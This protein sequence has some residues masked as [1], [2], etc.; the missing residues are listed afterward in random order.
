MQAWSNS[1][2]ARSP[3]FGPLDP[4]PSFLPTLEMLE[5]RAL[6]SVTVLDDLATTTQEVSVTIPVLNN[7]SDPQDAGPLMIDSVGNPSNGTTMLNGASIDYLPDASFVGIDLFTYVARD[8]DGNLGSGTVTVGVSTPSNTLPVAMDDTATIMEDTP[9]QLDVLSNDTDDDDDNLTIFSVSMPENGTTT[10]S[11]DKLSILYTPTPNTNG[12]DS[13]VYVIS[14]GNGGIAQATVSVTV[15]PVNDAPIANP[16]L[17]NLEENDP[18][19]TLNLIA[20]DTEPEG[21]SLEVFAVTALNPVD[22][23]TR[24]LIPEGVVFTPATDYVGVVTFVYNVSDP[25]GGS[26]GIDTATVTIGVRD[27]TNDSIPVANDDLFTVDEDSRNNPLPILDNDTDADTQDRLIVF[28]VMQPANGT[29]TIASNTLSV[30]YTPDADFFG[31]DTFTYITTDTRGAVAS[32]TVTITVTNASDD[33]VANDD[34]FN[35]IQNATA[36]TLDVLANDTDPDDNTLSI[37]EVT[38]P[39]NGSVSIAADNQSLVF[40][41]PMDFTGL[42]SFTYTISDGTGGVSTARVVVGIRDD[43]VNANPPTANDDTFDTLLEDSEDNVLDVLANDTDPDEDPLSI[44][45]VGQAN[46]GGT[47]VIDD[48]RLLYTPSANFVGTETFTYTISDGAGGVDLAT[49]TVVVENVPENFPPIAADDLDTTSVGVATTIDVLANDQDPDNAPAPLA[50]LSVANPSVGTASIDN[51]QVL[52]TPPTDFVGTATFT[53]TITDGQDT[54]SATVSVTVTSPTNQ[55]PVANPDTFAAT[56]NSGPITLDVLAN[57]SDPD[58]DSLT[59]TATSVP[60]NGGTVSIAND[61]SSLMYQPATDFLG[62]ETFTYTI[63]DGQGGLAT[64]TV[65]IVVNLGGPVANDDQF[66]VVTTTPTT[67][68]VLSNDS[69]VAGGTLTISAVSQ[70][71]SG[72]VAI[73][74]DN[75]ALTFTAPAGFTGELTFTYTVADGTGDSDTAEVTITV[76]T[77]QGIPQAND[78]SFRVFA[79]STLSVDASQSLLMNDTTPG[80]VPL[81]VVDPES[82][83]LL[84]GDGT[85][86]VNADGTF[87]FTPT[88]GFQGTVR[89]DYTASNGTFSDT[90]SV[91]ILVQGRSVA[92]FTQFA[93]SGGSGSQD[94]FVYDATTGDEAPAYQVT[95]F[96][97]A[98]APGG[99]RVALADV[100]GDGVP[101]V[102]A[103][104]GPGVSASVRILDGATQEPLSTITPFPLDP[105]FTGGVYVAAGD[106]NGDGFA[107]I[108]ITP[109]QGG[110]PVVA[111]YNGS[112]FVELKRFFGIEGDPNFRGG[113]RPALGDLNG[114][115]FLDVLISAGFQGGPRVA[116]FD[117]SNLLSTASNM[118]PSKIVGD[119]FVFEQSLRDG[120][121]LAAGDIDGDGMAELITG[122]GPQGGPRIRAFSGAVLITGDFNTN[123]PVEAQIANFFASNPNNRGGI[124]VTVRQTD[125]PQLR[126]AIVSAEGPGILPIVN[127]FSAENLAADP[128]DPRASDS[129]L[130]FPTSFLGGVFVG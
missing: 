71:S 92:S 82:I 120:A 22:A 14:D 32:A 44:V 63:S 1:M 125:D 43:Q 56:Q 126:A 68:D 70:P 64:T 36:T 69:V 15:T 130:P 85:L 102:I 90:A 40:T 129:L 78:D 109:D 30:T 115:G 94:V 111:I 17:F 75:L 48:A 35:I 20:N 39:T 19:T 47:V 5:S 101:D 42:G 7:D 123:D 31:E 86:V 10:L 55:A 33:P 37:T 103:G 98:E 24:T 121:F 122:G 105:S 61:G 127:V 8:V 97:S 27:R 6:P 13:F 52:Y 106:L 117:G 4:R 93:V 128:S 45:A 77:N 114:D 53:Y 110:G 28:S 59:I 99:I 9:I 41:P 54:D 65:S 25:V 73:T 113:A 89:F 66:T 18:A 12:E 2:K 51:G 87:T 108:V 49:V 72:Q 38:E 67:L 83:S 62:T 124:N 91:T 112:D 29:V 3:R 16:D 84:Q 76:D 60:P 58:D 26:G 79:G 119:F 100:T 116:L 107:E 88:S 80:G 50:I 104:T 21:E 11:V 81:T 118:Q 57:D 23:G 96:T 95:P 74:A 46:Q 34:V